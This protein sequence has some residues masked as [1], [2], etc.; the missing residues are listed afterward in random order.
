VPRFYPLLLRTA[1][2]CALFIGF[3]D[4]P[5]LGDG[6]PPKPAAA[7]SERETHLKNAT[8]LEKN[9]DFPGAIVELRAAYAIAPTW[10]VLFRVAKDQQA[11]FDFAHA[12]ETL[13]KILATHGDSLGAKD[14]QAVTDLRDKLRSFCAELTIEVTPQ[15]AIVAIDGEDKSFLA[16]A[17]RVVMVGPG[18]HR[19]AARADGFGE[20]QRTET[21]GVGDKKA[22]KL[23]LI[24]NAGFVTIKTNDPTTVLLLDGKVLGQGGWNGFVVPGTHRHRRPEGR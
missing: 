15:Q 19:I 2:A 11:L 8:F 12:V 20:D 21:F 23:A 17:P 14:K 22:I 1:F 4:S 18:S 3:A 24:P 16:G 7:P 6:T 10:D 5:A 13:E 9:H